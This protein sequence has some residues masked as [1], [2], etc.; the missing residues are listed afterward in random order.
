VAGKD[1][2]FY[3]MLGQRSIYREGWL[4][5]SMHPPLSGWGNF[6]R[7]VWELYDLDH[8]RSQ[9]TNLAE[10]EP[11]RLE[12]L[13]QLWFYYAGIYNGLPL[14][15]RSAIEQVL[16]ERPRP[17]PARDRYEYFPGTADVPEQAAPPINGRLHHRRG[18]RHGRRQR[19][20]RDLR[21]RRR[22]RW[23]QPVHQGPS[24]PVRVQLGWYP[25]PRGGGRS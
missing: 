6:E 17:G 1:T 7:D 3:A 5:C 4:A 23:A 19:R 16:A 25:S 24:A 11:G 14:D 8:D 13:K 2:Q 10:R 18:C 12:S 15:D 20:G 9:S 21:P 22:R